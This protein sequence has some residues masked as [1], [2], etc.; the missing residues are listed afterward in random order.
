[1]ANKLLFEAW[2]SLAPS[3]ELRT[4]SAG[5]CLSL[6][7]ASQGSICNRSLSKMSLLLLGAAP[8]LHSQASCRSRLRRAQPFQCSQGFGKADE[9]TGKGRKGARKKGASVK[10]GDAKVRAAELNCD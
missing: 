8:G 6:Q 9:G 2:V 1:M 3:S 10:G 7:L 4:S 5:M